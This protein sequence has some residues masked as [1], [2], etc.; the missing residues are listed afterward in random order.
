MS[1]CMSSLVIK[2]AEKNYDD[3]ALQSHACIATDVKTYTNEKLE[4][5]SVYVIFFIFTRAA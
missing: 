5:S 4:L 3:E 1:I 2:H